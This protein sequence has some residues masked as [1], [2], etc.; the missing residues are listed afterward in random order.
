M[1]EKEKTVIIM[2]I[3]ILIIAIVATIIYLCYFIDCKN[4]NAISLIISSIFF[5]VFI[6]LNF[7]LVLDYFIATEFKDD[8][9]ELVTKII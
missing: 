4:I 1:K 2:A 5:S 6:I 3:A 9:N 8:G 7:L